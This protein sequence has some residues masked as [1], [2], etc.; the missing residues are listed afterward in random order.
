MPDSAPVSRMDVHGSFADEASAIE[1]ARLTAR[2]MVDQISNGR[3]IEAGAR[4]KFV[5]CFVVRGRPDVL[6]VVGVR[7]DDGRV[8]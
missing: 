2:K 8:S 4:D 7:R 5:Q 6:T 1:R 3:M